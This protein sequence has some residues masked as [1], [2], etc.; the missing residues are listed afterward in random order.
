MYHPSD[1][2]PR[3]KKRHIIQQERTQGGEEGGVWQN[4]V[5]TP[6]YIYICSLEN[7]AEW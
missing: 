3:D 6:V 2:D 5:Y 7:L 1:T 4:P